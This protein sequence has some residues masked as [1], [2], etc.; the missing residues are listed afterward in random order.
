MALDPLRGLLLIAGLLAGG[1]AAGAEVIAHSSYPENAI[2]RSLLRGVFGMRVRAWPDGTPV[3]VFVLEDA[4]PVHEEFAKAVLQMYPWQLRHNWDRLLYSGTGQ[5]PVTV[6]SEEELLRR[7]AETPGG[8]GYLSEY[9]PPQA[10][11]RKPRTVPV[12][13]VKVI[14]VR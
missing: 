13:A 7:V 10:D 1:P 9:R 2:A 11:P 3:R 14:H 8:I 4:S 5:Q 12:P 6:T